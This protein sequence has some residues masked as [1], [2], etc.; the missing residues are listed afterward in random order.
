M[1][2]GEVIIEAKLN[3]KSFDAQIDKLTDKLDTLEQEYET[4]LK[5]KNFPKDELIKYR[6][7][8]EKTSNKLSDL[9]K[10][11][12]QLNQNHAF[13][14]L[15]SSI[16]GIVQ[17]TKKWV[18]AIFGVR[19]AY[20]AIRSAMSILS[21]SDE[22]LKTQIDY[23]KWALANAIKPIIEWIIKAV[24]TIMKLIAQIIY[25]FTGYNIFKD[26]GI[27]DYQKA[28]AGSNKS[29]KE[30]K[31]TLLGFDEMNVIN[32]NGSTGALGGGIGNLAKE[33][34]LANDTFFK[35][36]EDKKDLL[37]NLGLAA[38]GIFGAKTIGGWIS[39]LGKFLG[40]G[41]LSTLGSVLGKLGIIAGAISI[42]SIIKDKVWEEVDQLK[43]DIKKINELNTERQK[44]WI[45][46]ENDINKIITTINVNRQANYEL[47]QKTGG[48]WN[49]IN[50]LGYANLSTAKSSAKTMQLQV[51]RAI[52][53]YKQGKLNNEEQE[54]IKENIIQQVEYNDALI[55]RLQEEGWETQDIEDL[56]KRLIQNYK[57]MGGN[58]EEIK[59]DFQTINKIKFDDKEITVHVFGNTTSFKESMRRAIEYAEQGL[60]KLGF[61]AGGGGKGASGSGSGGGFRAKGGIFYPSKLPKLAVGGIINNPGAGVPYNGAIIGERGAEAVVPLTDSQQMALLGE[62]IGKYITVNL[63]NVTELDGRTIARKV[64]EVNNGTNFLLNR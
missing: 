58:V 14:K 45:K 61:S 39:N 23:M 57:D 8:I 12:N 20:L 63:T 7:E 49:W 11:Q 21:Q 42:I 18:L 2:S 3:T 5:D 60:E 37:K 16:N 64:Q 6:E 51:D 22:G 55:K 35:D 34:D 1:N 9:Y 27:A 17:K 38:A 19:S 31:R 50:D 43:K 26:S 54:K 44:K 13:E 56:N 33:F 41:K 52:E 40:S 59:T 30:L 29:A 46:E 32:E 4:A 62:A 15:G 36:L 48:A 47:L 28:M 10:K 24:Y 25:T 53:L